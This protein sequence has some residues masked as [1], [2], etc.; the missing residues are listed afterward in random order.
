MDENYLTNL[1]QVFLF[2][3]IKISDNHISHFKSQINELNLELE[4]LSSIISPKTPPDF[5]FQLRG[6]TDHD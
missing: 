6:V 3:D 1:E 2:H 5:S 4:K